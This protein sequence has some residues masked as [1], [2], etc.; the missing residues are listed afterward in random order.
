MPQKR[1]KQGARRVMASK[2]DPFLASRGMLKGKFSTEEFLKM[3][4]E[5]R[6]REEKDLRRLIAQAETNVRAGRVVTWREFLERERRGKSSSGDHQTT[7]SSGP[8]AS[9]LC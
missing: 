5:E 7:T 4:R 1:S 6:A 3:R 8:G 9:E 2:G